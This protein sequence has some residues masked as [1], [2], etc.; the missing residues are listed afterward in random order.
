M[1]N[2]N[3]VADLLRRLDIKWQNAW[4]IEVLEIVIIIILCIIISVSYCCVTNIHIITGYKVL[5][6]SPFRLLW[7]NCGHLT[8][9]LSWPTYATKSQLILAGRRSSELWDQP[10]QIYYV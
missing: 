6:S 4:H 9:D 7:I 3:T 10:A 1:G 2:K 8:T 5:A